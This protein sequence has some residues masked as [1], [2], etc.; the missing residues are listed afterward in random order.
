MINMPQKKHVIYV[1]QEGEIRQD[2][3]LAIS[4]GFVQ[5]VT[6][7]YTMKEMLEMETGKIENKGFSNFQSAAD[8]NMK[9]LEDII[10]NYRLMLKHLIIQ[11]VSAERYEGIL[12]LIPHERM[13]DIAIIYKAVI[14]SG[15]EYTASVIV[16]H[17]LLKSQGITESTFKKGALK[18][19][20][21]NRPVIIKGLKETIMEMTGTAYGEIEDH[22][23]KIF[24]AT[25]KDRTYGSGVI[26]YPGF[27]D[28]AGKQLKGSF[29]VLP[30]SIHEV[31]LLKDDGTM[32]PDALRDIV[33][34][35]NRTTVAP[36]DRLTDSVYR[37]DCNS[38][39][40]KIA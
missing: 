11:A 1:L 13:E 9:A 16:S 31:L 33:K 10:K 30:S 37:Y 38:G 18:Q 36:E 12:H 17:E 26:I 7:I 21:I 2:R 20:S 40:F 22:D 39:E 6:M 34:S 19:V 24:I 27:L 4:S 5:R 28:D 32:E 25:T 15:G 23:E 29:Y 8:I 35:V 3:C 14:E